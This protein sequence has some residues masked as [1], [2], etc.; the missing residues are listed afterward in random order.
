MW[1]ILIQALAGLLLTIGT[2]LV[3]LTAWRSDTEAPAAPAPPIAMDLPM[4]ERPRRA[5]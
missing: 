4:D 1:L 5:A 3:L 2:V